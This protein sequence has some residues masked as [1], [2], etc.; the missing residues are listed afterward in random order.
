MISWKGRHLK[1]GECPF[2]LWSYLGDPD[3]PA[4]RRPDGTVVARFTSGGLTREAIEREAL[5]DLP[6][7]S[8]E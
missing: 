3:V 7:A 4:L 8:R 2:I 1:I 5:E 6:S